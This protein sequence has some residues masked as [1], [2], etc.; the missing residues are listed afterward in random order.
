[1]RART[2]RVR[3][4]VPSVSS[5]VAS[6]PSPSF[7]GI[8]PFQIYG[9]LIALGVVAAVALSQRR[10]VAAGGHED[11]ISTLALWGV[12]AG[13][14]GARLYHVVTDF[15]K[16]ADEPWWKVFAIREGGLGIPGGM[17][18][19]VLTGLYI[20]KRR[21]IDIP[22]A[23]DAVVPALPLAQAIGRWGNYF[24]QELFGRPTNQPWGLE[25]DA[26]HRSSIPA[27]Y[28]DVEAFPTFHPT[29]LYESLWNLGLV[30]VILWVDRKGFLPKGRLIA[31]YLLGYGIGRAWV[32]ALRIDTVN[33]I[34]GLRLNI[35][36][37]I[38]LILGAVL[39]VMWPS[40]DRNKS[41]GNDA[42]DASSTEVAA[43]TV[44]S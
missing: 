36:M 19:G 7:S 17:L 21:G 25:I 13:V 32:E 2:R 29:F 23:L 15:Q 14:I 39:V 6:I 34:F 44:D 12:P 28:A 16:F 1:M 26:A 3:A 40:D 5:V 9:L 35:W 30:G 42:D 41:R 24:N 31:V 38:A 37:S 20:A 43:D 10:W 11:D 18:L 27:E 8:G 22:G 4:I 33:T